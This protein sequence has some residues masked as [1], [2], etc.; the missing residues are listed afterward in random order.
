[1]GV[2]KMGVGKMGVG[3]MAPIHCSDRGLRLLP[4]KFV[5]A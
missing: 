1:M 3:K 2:G 5:A 4:P